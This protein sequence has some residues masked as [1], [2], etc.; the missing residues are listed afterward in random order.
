MRHSWLVVY[1]LS[2]SRRSERW[3]NELCGHLGTVS[4]WNL[5]GKL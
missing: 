4:K 5:A 2:R 1:S 3:R